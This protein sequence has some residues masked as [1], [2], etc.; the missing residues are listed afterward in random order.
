MLMHFPTTQAM[1]R[2]DNGSVRLRDRVGSPARGCLAGMIVVLA[3]LGCSA[4]STTGSPTAGATPR[5]SPNPIPSATAS[6]TPTPTASPTPIPGFSATGLM[7]TQRDGHSATLLSDGRVLM[8]GGMDQ[9]DDA[10]ASAELFD[11]KSGTFSLTG[12]LTAVRASHTA[13][14]LSDG[15]VLIVGGVVHVPSEAP[16]AS[17]ELYD[18]KTGT[19]TPTGSMSTGRERHTATLLSDGR[20]LVVGGY[21]KSGALSSAEL[22]DPKTG[23]FSPTGSMITVRSAGTATLLSDGRLLV[24]GGVDMSNHTLASAELYDPATGTFSATGSMSTTRDFHTATL[25]HDGR[26]LIAGGEKQEA[27]YCSTCSTPSLA[28]AELYDPNR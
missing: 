15:R 9:Q 25:L 5:T 17:A 28:S 16:L 13:T 22:Y 6:P 26:V 10:L 21:G 23:T 24:A 3:V 20:V 27:G 1:T 8:A 2:R 7:T 18:P 19:F 12:S 11:P 14:L 4:G